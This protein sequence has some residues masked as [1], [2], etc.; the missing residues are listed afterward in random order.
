MYA[1]IRLRNLATRMMVVQTRKPEEKV[2]EYALKGNISD[3]Y[4]ATF[5]ER[6]QFEYPPFTILI[7]L[8]VEGSK[9][10]IS[11]TMAGIQKIM[12]SQTIDIFPAFTS[13]VRG[14]S[15]IHGL[16]KIK[17][18]NW[19]DAELVAKLRSLPHQVHVRIRA[20]SLL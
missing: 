8:T 6:K 9:D 7:K 14:N 3:F 4:H 2:F 20:E 11:K 18:E 10:V 19:P 5:D 17:Q 16:I 13:T 12:E 15:V 1:L